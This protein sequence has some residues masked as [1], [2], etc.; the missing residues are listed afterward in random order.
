MRLCRYSGLSRS[1]LP[2]RRQQGFL[3]G[4]P[5]VLIRLAAMEECRMLFAIQACAQGIADEMNGYFEKFGVNWQ[6]EHLPQITKK[7]RKLNEL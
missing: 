3:P 4:E 7:A 2:K 6:D 5:S 1:S